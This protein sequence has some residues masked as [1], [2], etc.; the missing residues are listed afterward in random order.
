MNSLTCLCVY[1]RDGSSVNEPHEASCTEELEKDL[2][3]NGEVYVSLSLSVET[4]CC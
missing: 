2:A 1:H 4:S 3:K